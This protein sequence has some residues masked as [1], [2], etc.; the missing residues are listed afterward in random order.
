MKHVSSRTNPI[1]D[2]FRQL[3]S[4]PDDSGYR[5]LLDGIHLVRDA[6]VAGWAFEA[7]AVG[8]AAVDA[9]DAS[10]HLAKKLDAEGHRTSVVT[11]PVLRALSPVRQSSGIVAI[12]R[13]TRPMPQGLITIHDAFIL[14]AVGVQDPGNVGALVRVAEAAGV[15]Q[16][17]VSGDSAHPF[18]WKALRGSMGS[19]LRVPVWRVPSAH[20]AVDAILATGATLIAAVPHHGTP[21]RSASWTGRVALVV[22][23]EGQ[24]LP[25]DL[26]ARCHQRVSVPMQPPVES[27][28]VA[29]AAA[30]L[31]YAAREQRT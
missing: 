31:V 20:T 15:N 8:A 16:V 19:L 5:L 11:E 7:V 12:A 23:G 18:A 17:I 24:G 30:I 28:N 25:P 14:V 9:D 10:A 1:V 27:L 13:R 21:P 22:G 2:Q 29:V 4:T 3:V 6:H 26:L